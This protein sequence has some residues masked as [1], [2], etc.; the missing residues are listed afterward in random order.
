MTPRL[1]LRGPLRPGAGAALEREAAH[2]LGRVLRLRT[3]DPVEVFDGEGARHAAVLESIDARGGLLRIGAALPSG[4]E[5][6]LRITLAQCISA[7]EKMD[8]TIEKA[9][10]LG[11]ARIVPL[12]SARSVVRLD[13]GRAQRRAEHWQRLV[14]AACMQCGRDRLPALDP[15][16]PLET[17]LDAQGGDVRSGDVRSGDAPAAELRTRDVLPLPGDAQA[18]DAR[19]ASTLRLIL[20]PGAADAIGSIAAP[21]DLAEVLLLVGPESGF[22]DA[23][24]ARARRAGLLPASLG[25]RILRTE[26]A[27]LAALAVLQARFGDLRNAPRTDAGA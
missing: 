11:V 17:W 9:V 5:S 24:L 12:Q 8:W 1:H 25:P 23:E 14:T 26:T 6:P 20:A 19:A 27:G 10:E 3:G 2:Y 22:T 21:A 13:A 16:Q 18:G 4:T 15:V 7:G